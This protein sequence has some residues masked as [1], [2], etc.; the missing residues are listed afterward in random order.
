MNAIF[1][2]INFAAA[3]PCLSITIHEFVFR[4]AAGATLYCSGM[5]NTS[6]SDTL[7]TAENV[8]AG[9]L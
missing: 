8:N 6:L 5:T 7:L 9:S 2:N 1:I 3:C 4:A